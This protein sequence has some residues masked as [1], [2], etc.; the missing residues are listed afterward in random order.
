VLVTA[1]GNYTGSSVT[2]PVVAQGQTFTN[3]ELV[4][5]YQNTEALENSYVL[6]NH[7]GRVAFYL[8]GSTKPTVGPFRAY[9]KEQA[10]NIKSFQVLFDVDGISLNP[11]SSSMGEENIYTLSG[12]K[13]NGRMVKAGV[14]IQNGKKVI[15]K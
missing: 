6:Q 8:V 12:V 1:S 4:G 5:V 2:V 7:N 10:N 9:I 15:I 13:V 14:Y 3:G 11:A